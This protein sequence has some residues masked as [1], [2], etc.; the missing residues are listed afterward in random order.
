MPSHRSRYPAASGI[1]SSCCLPSAMH[2]GADGPDDHEVTDVSGDTI[3]IRRHGVCHRRYHAQEGRGL[4]PLP[5][6]VGAMVKMG[7]CTARSGW[8][9]STSICRCHSCLP[10]LNL[11]ENLM[12]IR[13]CGPQDETWGDETNQGSQGH[14]HGPLRHHDRSPSRAR[15]KWRDGGGKTRAYDNILRRQARLGHLV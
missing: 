12:K 4:R 3:S 15:A 2:A 14:C 8:K 7:T 9:L 11:P 13:R 1:A 5:V 6:R 10:A